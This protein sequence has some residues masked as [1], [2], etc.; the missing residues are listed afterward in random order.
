MVLTLEGSLHGSSCYGHIVLIFSSGVPGHHSGGKV[1]QSYLMTNF[2][3]CCA[4]SADLEQLYA[5]NYGCGS[6]VVPLAQ[7]FVLLHLPSWLAE[8]SAR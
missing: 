2:L 5:L 4:Q 6:L 7:S 8:N 3:S 1:T